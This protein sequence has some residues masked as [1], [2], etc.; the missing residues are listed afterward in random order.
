[1]TRPPRNTVLV[2][3]A[4]QQLRALP[5]ASV[6][7]VITSPPYFRLRNY[8]VDGQYGDEASIDGWVE[9]LAR[10][11]TELAR[12]L[13][14]SGTLW[15]NVG[16]AY[17]RHGRSGAPAKSLLLGPERLLFR[18]TA[19]GWLVRN[20]IVWAKPNPMPDSARDR[21]ACTWEAVYCLAR[22]R[23]YFFDLEAIR[24][25]HRTPR[26]RRKPA[27][28]RPYLPQ[29][30]VGSAGN[31]HA[32]LQRLKVSG[33]VGHPLGKNPGDVWTIATAAYRGAHFATFPPALV[34]R[35]LL[36]G[37]P[38]RVCRRCRTPWRPSRTLGHLAVAERL[39]AACACGA[40]STPGVVLDPFMGAGTVAVVA[41]AHHRDWLG[42]EL[43]P[44]F[45]DLTSERLA[46]AQAEG[47]DH[48][49]A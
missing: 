43:N 38:E 5:S 39:T 13:V 34:R 11:C 46:A 27:N 21:L 17:S 29:A 30:W 6:E 15:L 25:P 14:P 24:E 8:G 18:L 19:D 45:V 28:S 42:I 31:D 4:R 9:H 22:S 20:K 47:A 26:S 40:P 33:R 12:V 10:V 49:A 32:G 37:C 48:R 23:R 16:D 7:C 36:A 3:D 2:G 41:E 44:A 35:P 1:M